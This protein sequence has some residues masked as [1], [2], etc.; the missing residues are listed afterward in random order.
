MKADKSVGGGVRCAGAGGAGGTTGE[1]QV[2]PSEVAEHTPVKPAPDSSWDF[3]VPLM[4]YLDP[5]TRSVVA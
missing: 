3:D 5:S 1:V 4:V 2:Y